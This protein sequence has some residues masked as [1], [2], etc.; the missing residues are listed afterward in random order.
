MFE[1][2]RNLEFDNKKTIFKKD[3]VEIQLFRPSKLSA[4]FKDY[5]LKKNFQI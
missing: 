4:R 2:I 3:D 5:D 1:I